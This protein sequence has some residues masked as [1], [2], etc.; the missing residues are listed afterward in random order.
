M[1]SINPQEYLS[2]II[3][4]HHPKFEYSQVDDLTLGEAWFFSRFVADELLFVILY[5][6]GRLPIEFPDWRAI[7]KELKPVSLLPSAAKL[8]ALCPDPQLIGVLADAILENG[9]VTREM[10]NRLADKPVGK[11]LI[12]FDQGRKTDVD[13]LQRLLKIDKITSYRPSKYDD[14]D[15][16]QDAWVKTLQLYKGQ[17]NAAL[18]QHRGRIRPI[19]PPQIRLHQPER[20]FWDKVVLRAWSNNL[21][22]YIEKVLPILDHSTEKIPEQT[23]QA[24]RTAFKK[25]EAEKRTGK[26]VPLRA[27]DRVF[28]SRSSSRTWQKAGER[29]QLGAEDKADVSA[30]IFAILKEAQKHKRW[31]PNAIKAFKYFLDGKTEKEAAQLA[32]ITE[33]TL[34]SDI[35]RLKK[36]F[37]RRK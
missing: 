37:L 18:R 36:I 32:G 16:Q 17:G 21:K 27:A 11:D 33:R 22:R 3:R 25:W 6:S 30:E 34:R 4:N 10:R 19:S 29:I 5:R 20:E 14:K 26:D 13:A 28:W 15:I 24:L 1:N 23:R 31:G 12:L 9:I 35:T 8:C 2:E 7:R